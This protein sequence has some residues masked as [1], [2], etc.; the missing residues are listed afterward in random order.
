MKKYL[1]ALLFIPFSVLAQGDSTGFTI[2]GKITGLTEGAEVKLITGGNVQTEAAKTTVKK[3]NFTLTGMVTEPSLYTIS[4]GQKSFQIYLDNSKIT[5]TGDV[6]NIDKLKVAGSSSHKDFEDFKKAFDPLAQQLNDAATTINSMMPG[7]D[8]DSLLKNY[9][10]IIAIIQIEID[11]FISEKPASPVSPFMLYVTTQ[12][13]E[14]FTLLEKRFKLLDSVVRHSQLGTS[15]SHYITYHKVGAIGSD[16]LDF[17]QPDTIGKPISLSSFRGKYV[18]VDFWASWCGPCRMENPNVVAA[19]NKFKEKNF[20]I[21]GVSLDRPG[22]KDKWIEAIKTDNLTWTN[23]SDLQFWNN[24]AAQLYRVSGI[25]F[26]MLVDPGGKIVG[27][28]L[29]GPELESRLCEI[30]GCN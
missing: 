23:V 9:Y 1:F 25:P 7:P 24:S 6:N 12:F 2:T 11:K 30:L 8:R 29:R 3:G 22:Q 16:A 10:G 27:R 26:N 20:T 19:Y 13:Y 5:L 21:L 18:L 15:L 28:N 17:T 14:D 4:F